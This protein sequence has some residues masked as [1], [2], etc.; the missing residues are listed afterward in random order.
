MDKKRKLI[1]GLCIAVVLL[2]LVAVATVLCVHWTS[3]PQN[4]IEEPLPEPEETDPATVIR[5]PRITGEE[6]Y[7]TVKEGRKENRELIQTLTADGYP[8]AYDKKSDQYY[9]S[10]SERSLTEKTGIAFDVIGTEEEDLSIVFQDPIDRYSYFIAEN[11]RAYRLTVYSD[12][13]YQDALI[14]TTTMPF[15]TINTEK[16]VGIGSSNVNCTITLRNANWKENGTAPFTESYANIHT[17]GAS[18]AGFPK[19]AYKLNLREED[20]ETPRDVSLLGLRSDNDW[21][22]DALYIDHTRMHNKIATE[23][24]NEMSDQNKASQGR[25]VEVILNGNYAGL[26]DLIEPVDRKQLGLDKENSVLIK[27]TNWEGTLF[28]KYNG[29]PQGAAWMDFEV[30]YP[31]ENVTGKTWGIFYDLVEATA[32]SD[33]FPQYFKDATANFDHQNLTDYWLFLTAFSLRDNR[34][35]NLYWSA[36]D[37]NAD[38]AVLTVTPWDCDIGFGYRYGK[39]ETSVL[40]LPCFRDDYENDYIDDFRLLQ[41]YLERDVNGAKKTVLNRW[42]EL[43]A[44]GG[45]LSLESVLNRFETHRAYLEE[46]GAWERETNCWPKGMV[47]DPDE[48][49]EYLEE[50]MIGRYEWMEERVAEVTQTEEDAE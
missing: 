25:Y 35:K 7:G 12:T 10:V 15:M 37:P 27:A 40:D 42:K 28:D 20:Y 19:K 6:P 26:Y 39:N 44:Q 9:L 30:V 36:N 17:R 1:L 49:F 32:E 29:F 43:S 46:T 31:K 50:W 33:D 4:V 48:E 11:N 41:Q 18:A 13:E 45:V 24:W 21:V 23:I 16:K 38:D 47:E 2:S 22:L 14:V 8:I 34:G 3:E 5:S